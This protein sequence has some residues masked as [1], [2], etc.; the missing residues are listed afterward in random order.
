MA[1]RGGYG[2]TGEL[3]T[4]ALI[5][6]VRKPLAVALGLQSPGKLSR[7]R[8][9]WSQ[10]GRFVERPYDSSKLDEFRAILEGG[11]VSSRCRAQQHGFQLREL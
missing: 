2:Q 7:E 9:M 10:Y 8:E 6:V 11:T 4:R 1:S 3:A 5:N